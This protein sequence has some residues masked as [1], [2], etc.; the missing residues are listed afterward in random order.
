MNSAHRSILL[1]LLPCF[2]L[3]ITPA[4]AQITSG[5][6]TVVEFASG[7]APEGASWS[8]SLQLTARGLETQPLHQPNASWEVW[9]Q[10]PPIPVGPSWR[11]PT[12]ARLQLTMSGLTMA[13]Q[14]GPLNAYFRYS[15]DKVHWSSWYNMS[16]LEGS[17]EPG[18]TYQSWLSLPRAA[19]ARYEALMQEWWRTDPDWSSD[20]HEFCVWLAQHHPDFFA[21]ELPFIGYVQ[22]RVEGSARAARVPAMR[23]EQRWTV[24]GLSSPARRRTRT[25]TGERWFFDLSQFLGRDSR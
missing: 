20:E 9:V 6:S 2:L 17:V 5:D 14:L 8:S 7:R 22:V 19:R 25:T 13:D 16:A 15:S 12:A 24:S 21:T 11:P 4:R 3:S 18:A 1:L 10:S 23:V